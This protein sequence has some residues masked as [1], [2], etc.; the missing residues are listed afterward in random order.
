MLSG[1]RVRLFCG[2]LGLRAALLRP[3][4]PPQWIPAHSVAKRLPP[5]VVGKLGEC[6]SPCV[7]APDGYR[8]QRSDLPPVGLACSNTCRRSPGSRWTGACPCREGP[9]GAT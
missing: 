6:A 7:L 4:E 8:P 3:P 1:Q 5:T 2:L 9:G